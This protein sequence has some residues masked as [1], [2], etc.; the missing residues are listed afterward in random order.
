MTEFCTDHACGHEGPHLH[1][2][3]TPRAIG[4]DDA[5]DIDSARR[6][7]MASFGDPIEPGPIPD[8]TIREAEA[9]KG[10]RPMEIA[11]VTVS[12][13]NDTPATRA[14]FGTTLS[15]AIGIPNLKLAQDEAEGYRT[16]IVGVRSNLDFEAVFATWSS[17][18]RTE[19]LNYLRIDGLDRDG[20]WIIDTDP[21]GGEPRFTVAGPEEAT[22]PQG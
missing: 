22:S 8:M 3:P 1:G 12:F 21:K 19:G 16:W 18:A 5:Q 15:N 2:M 17:L 7:M 9:P 6:M 20:L 14:R 13:E 10:S 4:P 11:Q